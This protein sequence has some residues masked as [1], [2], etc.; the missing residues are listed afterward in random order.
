LEKPMARKT[1]TRRGRPKINAVR[2]A[3]IECTSCDRR[4]S[5]E[6]TACCDFRARAEFAALVGGGDECERMNRP[7]VDCSRTR[8]RCL[9]RSGRRLGRSIE[10]SAT[11]LRSCRRDCSSDPSP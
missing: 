8:L 4:G 10:A 1:G 11:G 7:D 9:E 3:I 6:R 5:H 2:V